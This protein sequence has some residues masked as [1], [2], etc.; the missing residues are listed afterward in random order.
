M[1]FQADVSK[2]Q[3]G[4]LIVGIYRNQE[5]YFWAEGLLLPRDKDNFEVFMECA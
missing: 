4:Q 2:E 3:L 5:S 1:I